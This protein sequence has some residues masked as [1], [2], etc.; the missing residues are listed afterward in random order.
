MMG[1]K[2]YGASSAV[3]SPLI[4]RAWRIHASGTEN[5]PLSGAAILASN[6]LSYLDHYT[7]PAVVP[8]RRMVYFISKAQH[9]DVPVQRWLFKQWGVIPL[10]RGEGDAEALARARDILL[11][12]DLLCIYPEGTRSTDGKLHRGRTGVARLA[13]ETRVPVIPVA[14]RGTDAALP[15]GKNWPKFIEVDVTFGR[16]LVLDEF[17]GLQDDRK[18]TREVTDR[19]MRAIQALSGQEYLDSYAFSPDYAKRPTDA[20]PAEASAPPASAPTLGGEWP[21]DVDLPRDPPKP[22]GG[23]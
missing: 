13:L 9:F 22:P 1:K 21:G 15:K 19:I 10:R 16:P 2:F 12:G 4:R 23:A 3:L 11:Q 5:V 18:V 20:G 8:N 6:H 7:M 14:M 17:A